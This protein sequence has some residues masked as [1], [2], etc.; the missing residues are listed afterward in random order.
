[1]WTRTALASEFREVRRRVWRVVEAQHRISTNRLAASIADQA[2]LEDLAEAVKPLVPPAA[3]HLH[4]LLASPFRYGHRSASRF[5]HA[6]ERPGIF[7]ASEHEHTA[8]AES[9]Y[10]RLRFFTRSPGFVPPS[11]VSE[12]SSFCVTI[13][14]R[15]TIDLTQAPFAAQEAEWLSDDYVACQAL[16]S[17][18]RAA[19]AQAIRYRS[20]RDPKRRANVALL[21]PAGFAETQPRTG[22]TWHLRVEQGRLLALAAFPATESLTFTPAQFGL[23][24]RP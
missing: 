13:A 22:Q 2:L 19:D 15:R 10:W 8:I 20:A 14:A 16:S 4:Y 11:T 9:A 5:R 1:M 18:A 17:E 24:Q 7:Y 6:D 12:H 23:V 21:D 3:R